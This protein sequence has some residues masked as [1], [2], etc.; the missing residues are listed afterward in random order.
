MKLFRKA[1]WLGAAMILVLGSSS[2]VRAQD[3]EFTLINIKYEGKVIWLPSLLVVKKGEKVKLTLVN[4][5]K[6]DPEVHGYSIPQFDVKAD[7]KRGTPSIV[8]FMASE[9]GLFD[10]NCHLHPAHLKGQILVL[11]K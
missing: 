5:V 10:T 3:R 1:V 7:V 9:A 4:N 6:D 2:G 8:E 11:E